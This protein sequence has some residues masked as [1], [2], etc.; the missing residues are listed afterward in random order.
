MQL[1]E[2]ELDEIQLLIMRVFTE[3]SGDKRIIVSSTMFGP[4]L[5]SMGFTK[6]K[7]LKELGR[8]DTQEV[9]ANM[10]DLV[11]QGLLN[12]NYSMKGTPDYSLTKRGYEIVKILKNSLG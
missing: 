6:S 7:L 8:M 5:E 3:M 2:Q 1:V 10:D 11:A 4:S 12:L 9:I